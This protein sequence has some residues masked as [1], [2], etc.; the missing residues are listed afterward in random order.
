VTDGLLASV[1]LV[2]HSRRRKAILY[3]FLSRE[4][5]RVIWSF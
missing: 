5:G 1:E 2:T 4:R 3:F